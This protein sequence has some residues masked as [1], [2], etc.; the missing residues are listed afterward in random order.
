[1]MHMVHLMMPPRP[2]PDPSGTCAH[3][4]GSVAQAAPNP[5]HQQLSQSSRPCLLLAWAAMEC[6]NKEALPPLLLLL[7]L[8]LHPHHPLM[9]WHRQPSPSLDGG[10]NT[11]GW[12]CVNGALCPPW[13]P[14]LQHRWLH[15]FDGMMCGPSRRHL[16]ARSRW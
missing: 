15:A 6:L 4:G 2:P 10:M 5:S 12:R 14:P 13:W 11:S 7:L 1:M 3:A 16:H 8:L 9:T